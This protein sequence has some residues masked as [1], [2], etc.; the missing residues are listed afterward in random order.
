MQTCN[1]SDLDLHDCTMTNCEILES[2]FMQTKLTGANFKG[3][4][5]TGTT[6]L[7]CNLTRANF[8]NAEDYLINPLRNRIEKA[9]FSLPEAITLLKAFDIIIK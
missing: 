1:F 3:S 6:F 2:D 5:F 4:K 8:E 9:V 7:D